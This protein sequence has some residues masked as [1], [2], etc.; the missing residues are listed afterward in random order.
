MRAQFNCHA[1][2]ADAVQKFILLLYAYKTSSHFIFPIE[3]GLKWEG[4]ELVPIA[5]VEFSLELHP[6]QPE[7]VQESR[8]TLHHQQDDY[9][10]HYKTR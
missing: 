2:Y 10:L 4:L 6:V 1:H 8:Q 7:G 5:T 3:Y 9:G